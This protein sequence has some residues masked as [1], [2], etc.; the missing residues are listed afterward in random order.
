MKMKEIV[1]IKGKPV[2]EVFESFD[3]SY[4]FV[5]ERLQKGGQTYL[6]GYIRSAGPAHML[7]EFRDLPEATLN[8]SEKSIWKVANKRWHMCPGIELMKTDKQGDNIEPNS[9]PTYFWKGASYSNNCK[10][11]ENESKY[12][13]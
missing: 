6:S 11:V 4:W 7:V 3:G 13:G 8:T 10:E 9:K 1:T 5:T 12:T 2:I